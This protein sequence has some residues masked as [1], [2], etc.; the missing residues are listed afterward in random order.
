[1][2]W[3]NHPNFV[4][5]VK[6]EYIES[7]NQLNNAYLWTFAAANESDFYFQWKKQT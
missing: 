4:S 5:Q 1:M 2:H 7:I 6:K 3:G